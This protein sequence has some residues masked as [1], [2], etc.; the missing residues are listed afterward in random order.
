[1]SSSTN[2]GLFSSGVWINLGEPTDLAPTSI[3]G[4][5]VQEQTLGALNN[6]IG[7]C[8]TASGYTGAG[9]WNYDVSP[10]LSNTEFALLDSMFQITYYQ[11]LIRKNSG[12]GGTKIVQQLTEGDTKIT[13]VSAADMI[14]ALN[15]SLKEAT[16]RLNYQ[17]N[18]YVQN[19][20]G[21]DFARSID[22][23][24]M[25]QNGYGAVY[26]PTIR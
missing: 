23:Y 17:V 22:H 25:L 8:Y 5:V 4:W 9:S 26:V 24:T 16:K 20:L 18:E 1:M 12:A 19:S 2:I 10:D 6:R 21:G 14:R 15:D 11:Q 3:S 13:Y 7:T